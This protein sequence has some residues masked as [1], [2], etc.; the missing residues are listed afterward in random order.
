MIKKGLSRGLVQVYTGCGKGKTTAALG[1]A[2]RAAGHRLKV[3]VIQFLKGGI[4]YGELR[5]AKKLIPYLTI[6]PMGRECFVHKQNPDPTD[7]RLAREAWEFACRSIHSRRYQLVILDEINVAVEYGMVPL[8]GLLAL[9][10]NKPEDVELV[11]T[12]RWAKPSVLRS[13]DLVT[14]MKEIKHYYRKGIES[15]I[16]IER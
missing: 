11:L 2:L 8:K 10:K 13:A 6:V 12:G 4:A 16:G 14:E 5:S 3:L 15:R 9:M 1:L 7:V